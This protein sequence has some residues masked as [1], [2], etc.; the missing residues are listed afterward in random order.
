MRAGLATLDVLD[1]EGLGERAQAMGEV[2]RERLRTALAGYEMV[3]EVRGLG[4]L[5][6]IEFQAPR[7]L[8]LRVPFEAFMAI[9]KGMFGQVVVMRLF[10]DHGMLTQICGNNFLVLKVAPPLVVEEGQIDEFVDGD[11]RRGR[12]DAQFSLLL[13]GG[14]GARAASPSQHIGQ[15]GNGLRQERRGGR[16]RAR[17]SRGAR[18]RPIRW[19]NL[20]NG[21]QR[22]VWT[23][24]ACI[25]CTRELE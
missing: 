17:G 6:G 12:S 1:Q 16:P 5:N 9:H 14:A 22:N 21:L 3:A 2:L 15:P 10:R 23:E 24:C 18:G 25:R 19:K 8:K 7:S 4:L 11:R 20:T 13:D